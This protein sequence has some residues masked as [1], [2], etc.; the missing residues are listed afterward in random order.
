M[1]KT[2]AISLFLLVFV[3]GCATN[4]YPQKQPIRPVAVYVADYGIH[5]SLLLPVDG[6]RYVE[7][8]FGDWN[9][10]AMNHC[11]PQDALG[12]LL[13]SFQ[14]T[15]G[16]R[17][18][19]VEPGK[20]EPWPAHPSPHKVQVVYASEAEVER[21]VKDLDARFNRD[22]HLV[23]HNSENDM[24]FVKDTEHY[25][26]LNNCNHL[27]ARCLREMGCDVRGLVVLST[28]SVKPV[29][30]A[31]PKEFPASPPVATAARSHAATMP[32]AGA[33]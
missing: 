3:G 28:F 8:A 7:Y 15:L 5:S 27:T 6:G 32:T 24:D 4:V 16:R 10:A 22:T 25:S 23:L 11:W 31:A 2:I 20:T 17:Y 12:A 21:V 30:G 29:P 18:I 26:I 19:T 13:I 33:E 9:F 1:A 14:S